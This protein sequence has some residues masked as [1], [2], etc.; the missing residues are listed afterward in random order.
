[1][2]IGIPPFDVS[3]IVRRALPRRKGGEHDPEKHAL[4]TDRGWEPVSRLRDASVQAENESWR[5][6]Y[7]PS[8]LVGEGIAGISTYSVG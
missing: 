8:P 2:R 6:P 3:R 5:L 4:D 7:L 1:M